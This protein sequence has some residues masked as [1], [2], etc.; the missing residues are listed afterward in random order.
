MKKIIYPLLFI[1]L[2]ILIFSCKKSSNSPY[3]LTC[4]INGS[5]KSFNDSTQNDYYPR[6]TDLEINCYSSSSIINSPT[7]KISIYNRGIDLT[8]GSYAD[9]STSCLVSATYFPLS[10]YSSAYQAGY[11]HSSSPVPG[12]KNLVITIS[13]ISST[14]IKG[15]FSGELASLN[16]TTNIAHV[17]NGKFYLRITRHS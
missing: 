17:T 4:D 10:I 8:N 7:F 11:Y 15:T 2:A 5:H 3:Y 1:F 6:S 16:D 13:S 12:S 9:T 14:E